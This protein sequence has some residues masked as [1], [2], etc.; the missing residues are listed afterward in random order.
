MTRFQANLLLI[1]CILG[2]VVVMIWSYRQDNKN[3][4]IR[5]ELAACREKTGE[6]GEVTLAPIPGDANTTTNATPFIFSSG[7]QTWLS[8]QSYLP[9]PHPNQIDLETGESNG[10]DLI[11]EVCPQ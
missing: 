9:G 7:A 2:M 6:A 3:I 4:Q 1:P 11:T 8:H 10:F 5:K